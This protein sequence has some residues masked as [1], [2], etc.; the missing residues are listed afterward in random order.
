[1]TARNFILE[2]S[3][4]IMEA[5]NI[6]L[7]YLG[8]VQKVHY[9]KEEKLKIALFI[10][11]YSIFS[12]WASIGIPNGYHS[13]LIILLSIIV[14]SI[15]TSTRMTISSI[16]VLASAIYFLIV[17]ITIMLLASGITGINFFNAEEFQRVRYI[18]TVIVKILEMIFVILIMYKRKNHI[19]KLSYRDIEEGNFVYWFLGMFLMGL[20]VLSVNFINSNKV[21]ML[22]YN[23]LLFLIFLFFIVIGIIDYRKKVEL[24]NIKNKFHVREEYI[25]NLEAVVD[26][27]RKEK[28]DFANHINTV[29]A[30]CILNRENST[31]RIKDYLKSITDNLQSSYKFYN[32]G[33]T[34]VDG[35][36][37]VKSNYAFENNIYLDVD[38][39]TSLEALEINDNDLVAILSNILDNAF[40]AVLSEPK[41]KKKI[42]SVYGYIE[43]NKYYLSIANNGPMISEEAKGKI[44]KKGF[45]TKVYNKKE[46]G[47]GLFIVE[48]LIRKNEGEIMFS[49]SEEETEFLFILKVKKGYCGENS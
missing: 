12:A 11:L 45:S 9:F 36:I 3:L 13:V 14:L 2:S 34:Y 6:A 37:A 29:Y 21:D 22:L 18:F 28:H 27:I 20:V 8:V 17:E 41:E 44:F 26:I 15:L 38:F 24:I 40:H 19:L 1:M 39:E 16:G 4:S 42:V 46:H 33:N 32:T 31:E 25:N 23:I 49:S 48:Q 47:F 5:L 43:S 35:L 30:I 7:I 10:I